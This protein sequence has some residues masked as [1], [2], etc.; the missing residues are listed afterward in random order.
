MCL[1]STFLMKN[2]N[3]VESG[4]IWTEDGKNSFP[5]AAQCN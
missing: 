2:V 4:F 1:A 5:D 3:D